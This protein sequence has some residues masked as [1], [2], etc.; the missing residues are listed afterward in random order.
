MYVDH[1]F[2]IIHLHHENESDFLRQKLPTQKPRPSSHF[3]GDAADGFWDESGAPSPPS[4]FDPRTPP[5]SPCGE[6]E[7]ADWRG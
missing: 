3:G 2:L 4:A 7:A 6:L 1:S 5:A